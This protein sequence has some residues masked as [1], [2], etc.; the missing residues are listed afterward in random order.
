M[1]VYRRMGEAVRNNSFRS[2]NVA[3]NCSD[4]SGKKF[5]SDIHPDKLYPKIVIGLLFKTN[6]PSGCLE[7]LFADIFHPVYLLLL[8][9]MF[10]GL[11]LKGDE[12]RVRMYSLRWL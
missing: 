10:S 7:A 2:Y 4:N 6:L 9:L 5:H 8:L 3:K 12:G 11:S 1:E